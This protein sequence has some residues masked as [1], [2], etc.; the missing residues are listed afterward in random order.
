MERRSPC[1]RCGCGSGRRTG[2]GHRAGS[3]PGR[4]R[5]PTQILSRTPRP[6][7]CGRGGPRCGPSAAGGT[8]RPRRRSR[9]TPVAAASL[10]AHPGHIPQVAIA[11][12]SRSAADGLVAGGW[13]P[14]AIPPRAETPEGR[15]HRP[16]TPACRADL[17]GIPGSSGQDDPGGGLLSRP[18]ARCRN[19]FRSVSLGRS[20]NPP[21]R[22]LRNGLSTV[23]AGVAGNRP[24]TG[25]LAASVAVPGDRN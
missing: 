8:A 20:P 18:G 15:G 14:G 21:C 24:G 4:R 17:A 3:R 16:R 23:S 19:C 5:I 25:D 9:D 7:G 11:A 22:S 13:V 6:P 2:C 10:E 12:S 1:G